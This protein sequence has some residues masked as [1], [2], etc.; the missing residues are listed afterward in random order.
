VARRIVKKEIRDLRHLFQDAQPTTVFDVGANVGFV[1]WELTRAF[2]EASIYAFE[3]NPN[4]Y[5]VLCETHRRNPRV[6]CFPFAI[7]NEAGEMT[8]LQRDVSGN[9]SLLDAVAGAGGGTR[10][11]TVRTQT[12][13]GMCAEQALQHIDLLK[14]DTEGADLLALQG[15][16]GMLGEGAIDVVMT[17]VLLV[18]TFKGQPALDEI[19]EFLRRYGFR[20]F[21]FYVGHEM[22]NGQATYGN[23]I[24]VRNGARTPGLLET[25]RSV[26]VEV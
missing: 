14:I 4:A 18:P 1:T 20:I 12:V 7:A 24:F 2:Q 13:D 9:S 21:N 10:R 8:F 5:A 26:Y 3:P 15:A 19:A 22:S 6:H 17:E 16:E 23:M 11:I 25:P